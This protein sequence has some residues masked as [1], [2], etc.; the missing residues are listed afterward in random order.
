MDVRAR[1]KVAAVGVALAVVLAPAGPLTQRAFAGIF[2]GGIVFPPA[3]MLNE[4]RDNTALMAV[5]SG[6]DTEAVYPAVSSLPES[7]TPAADTTT[8]TV[9]ATVIDA[10]YGYLWT[11]WHG[12]ERA[13]WCGPSS[14]QIVAHYFG[15]LQTQATMAS[16]LGTTSSGTSITKVDDCLR[17]Y[18]GRAYECYTGLSTSALFGKV[19][20][21]IATHGQPLVA[22]V[23]IVPG[24]WYAYRF[25]HAGHIIPVE[26]FDWRWN[27]IRVDDPY[28]EASYQSHGGSTGGHTVYPASA[29]ADGIARHPQHAVVAAP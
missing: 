26:A 29:L 6:V 20:H 7:M 22:D 3:D 13:Y 11:P 25:A 28:N 8:P 10:P 16:F 21:S 23:R 4:P 18:T 12:Q 24:V 5:P 19:A 2:D 1:L 14:C 17:K 27:I 15:N 9:G